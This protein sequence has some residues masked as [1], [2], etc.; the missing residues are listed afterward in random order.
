MVISLMPCGVLLSY[1]YGLGPFRSSCE[2]V[3]LPPELLFWSLFLIDLTLFSLD[4]DLEP[5]AENTTHVFKQPS[6]G[7]Y[8]ESRVLLA[9]ASL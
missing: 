3:S 8:F 9:C 4:H 1:V 7:F 6:Y 5:F 2:A